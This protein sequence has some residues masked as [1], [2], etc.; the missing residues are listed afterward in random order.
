MRGVIGRALGGIVMGVDR[1]IADLFTPVAGRLS[2]LNFG[3][4]GTVWDPIDVNVER[5]ARAR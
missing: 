5:T 3:S 2:N 1:G 4:R